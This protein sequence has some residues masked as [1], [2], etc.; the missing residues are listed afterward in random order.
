MIFGGKDSIGLDIGSTYIKTVKLKEAKAGYE[1]ELFHAHPLPPELIVEGSIIDS[2]R[3][4]SSL[5][6][7]VKAA[8]IKTKNAVIAIS[9]H[10]SVII[11]RISLPEMTEEELS[12]SI[13]FEAEQYVPFNIEDVNLDF[14]IIGPKEEAGQMDVILVAVKKDIINE[15]ISVVKEAGLNPI[16]VDIGSFALEN[17]YGIN[18]ETEPDKNAALLNIGASAI[19]MIILKG[20][21]SVFARDSSLGSNL[22]TEALQ[23]EFNISHENAERLKRGESVENV[24]PEDAQVV[25]ASASEEILNEI[26]RSFDYYRSAVIHEDISEIILSGG[27]SLIG[28]FVSMTAKRSGIKT[29]LVEPFRNIKIP[30]KFDMTYIEETAPM[31]AVAVGLALRKQGDR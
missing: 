9:G 16:I 28:N 24:S 7:M 14:Q 4:S 21:V 3:L 6:E 29:R 5:K 27:C 8:G 19:N 17:M 12:E 11:K 13:K 2:I 22:H 1:L 20:G 30:R 18:Y 10:S 31:M 23:R 15:Y 25:M 26:M